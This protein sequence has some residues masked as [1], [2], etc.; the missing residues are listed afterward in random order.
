MCVASVEVCM[1][2]CVLYMCMHIY[3]YI[4]R[5]FLRACANNGSS[6]HLAKL[7]E[8]QIDRYYM[9]IYIHN[10]AYIRLFKQAQVFYMHVCAY[11][12]A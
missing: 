3:I 11:Y 8:C 2:V 5:V 10:S 12:Y 9:Y 7:K 4:S 6:P 1:C